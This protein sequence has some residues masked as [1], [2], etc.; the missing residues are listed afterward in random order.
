MRLLHCDLLRLRRWASGI[1]SVDANNCYDRVGHR[2]VTLTCQ[3]MGVGLGPIVSMFSAL[4]YMSF[5]IRTG[6]GD[7]STT[8]GGSVQDP[9]EG[10]GQGN[11]T[12]PAG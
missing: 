3:A 6:F 1:T 9:Y 4:S 5:H 12:A 2:F 11:G 7:S 10:L 8:Y